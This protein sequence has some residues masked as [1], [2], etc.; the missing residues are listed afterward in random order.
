MRLTKAGRRKMKETLDSDIVSLDVESLADFRKEE[1]ILQQIA[2]QAR[3]NSAVVRNPLTR[4]APT[5]AGF[6][7]FPRHAWLPLLAC[8]G[9]RHPFPF[10]SC[11]FKRLEDSMIVILYAREK[12]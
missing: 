5:S 11:P 4:T 6:P 2:S 3:R 12:S 8:R 9:N 1:R 10:F 7:G